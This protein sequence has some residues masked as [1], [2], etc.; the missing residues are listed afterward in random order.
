MVDRDG[1]APAADAHNEHA[2]VDE[3]LDRAEL[4]DRSRFGRRDDPAPVAPV[5]RHGPATLDPEPVGS[6]AV[7]DRADELLGPAEG[8]IVS[9]DDQ[10]RQQR[11]HL[12]LA[13]EPVD[14]L[15]IEQIADHALAFGA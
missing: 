10:L 9:I 13:G 15:L 11:R 1:N 3:K 5:R 2:G 12:A 8:R 7:V 14:E 6:G 4:D